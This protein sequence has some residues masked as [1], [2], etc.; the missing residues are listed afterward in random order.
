MPVPKFLQFF[1]NSPVHS[2]QLFGKRVLL[3]ACIFRPP[4]SPQDYNLNTIN[5]LKELNEFE[6]DQMLIFGDWLL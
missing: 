4:E 5:V 3:I 2:Y 6:S 1:L